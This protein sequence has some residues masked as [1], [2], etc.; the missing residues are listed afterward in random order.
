MRYERG[1]S[2]HPD[3]EVRHMTP[4]TVC[5]VGLGYVG[6][7][8]SVALDG[9]G[10]DV[11]GYDI[12]DDRV[13]E[14]AA[15]RD[16]TG[17][18]EPG[19]LEVTTIEFTADP[20]SI[21]RCDVVLLT[22]PTPLNGIGAPELGYVRSAAETIGQHMREGTIVVLESTVYPGATRDVMTT[23]LAEVS[24]LT[25][26][27]DF[28]VGYSPERLSPGR[29][30]KRLDEVVKIVS[31]DTD[32]T[33][34]ELVTLYESIVDAG[35]YRAPSIETAEAAKV[36]ENVQRDINIALMNELA[37]IAD[38]LDLDTTEIIEAAATKWNFHDYRPGLV[39]GHCIPV[40][41][42]YMIHGSEQAGFSPKLILQ[43]REINEY[44]PKHLADVTIKAL[45]T[46]EK[47]LAHS[48]LL[49]LG[50]TYKPNVADLRT[51]KV[52]E[53]ISSLAEYDIECT[54]YDPVAPN[55]D[56]EHVFSVD[57]I[58]DPPFTEL[59]GIVLATPH[60]EFQSFDFA[61]IIGGLRTNP[62]FIDVTG[63]M[64]RDE[65]TEMG[66]EYRSL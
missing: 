56:I 33:L 9:A 52:R 42:H 19:A 62:I 3:R 25:A 36:L 48:R 32:E 22:V 50:V 16:P 40:D 47:V 10:H 4:R 44:M 63:A 57:T 38:H 53:Y 26:G 28:N 39:G 31:G 43:A 41:P 59:D 35:I 5:V 14:L 6:L 24:G 46:A 20:A 60:D 66:Y 30:G 17:E 15:G 12:D 49:V 11:I 45:N 7:P 1:R 37:I 27:A 54:I 64:D 8:L 2:V 65:L 34:D 23:E 51:S 21:G 29:N 18:L 58:E 61:D 13:H 55:A